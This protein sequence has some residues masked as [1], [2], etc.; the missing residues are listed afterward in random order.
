MFYT[1]M[2]SPVGQLLIAGDEDGIKHL[3]FET[4]KKPTTPKP[5]WKLN[6]LFFTGAITQL[7]E[8]FDGKRTKFQLKLAPTGTAF[9]IKV[10]EELKKIPYG[11][12]CSYG[13]IANR[14]GN[15]NA[16]RAVG[17]A[18]GR[19]PVS[20]IIPCHRVIGHSGKLVGFGGGL[21]TKETLLSIEKRNSHRL[22][23]CQA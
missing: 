13:D 15:P 19:N 1:Y 23:S 4:G 12:T 2:K 7:Q 8:Y 6:T 20:I 5:G 10:L 14:I 3:S 16:S 17:A 11:E 9:Q 21:K 22:E 18:N